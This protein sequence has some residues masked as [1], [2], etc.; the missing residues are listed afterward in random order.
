MR[1]IPCAWKK[2][3]FLLRICSYYM[4]SCKHSAITFLSD[5]VCSLGI[6]DKKWIYR[7]QLLWTM[8]F[9]E[10]SQHIHQIFAQ[11]QLFRKG[12]LEIWSWVL[13]WS[14]VNIRGTHLVETFD[15]PKISFRIDCTAPQLMPTKLAMLCRSRLLLHITRVCTTLTYS[16]VVV[17]F[18][19]QD[20][21]PSSSHSLPILNSAVNI[22][23][24]L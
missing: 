17:S 11:R 9:A 2:F 12:I 8:Q 16:S 13:L 19:Q 18:G 14:S 1:I 15:I 23:T 21:P 4:K 5:Q 20:R 3:K 10:Y 6:R 7:E 24:V 22:F